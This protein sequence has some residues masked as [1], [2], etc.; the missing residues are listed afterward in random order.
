LPRLALQGQGLKAKQRHFRFRFYHKATSYTDSPS[1]PRSTTS[2]YR[3]RTPHTLS[4]ISRGFRHHVGTRESAVQS[5]GTS[6]RLSQASRLVPYR[7]LSCAIHTRLR[8]KLINMNSSQRSNSTAKQQKPARTRRPRR[9][10]SRRY[11]FPSIPRI[12]NEQLMRIKGHT[13]RTQ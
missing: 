10:S 4:Y 11:T 3:L 12:M 2:R 8:N 6:Q 7:T 13:A 5:E 9:T 1:N